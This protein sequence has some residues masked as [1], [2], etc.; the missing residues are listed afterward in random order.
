MRKGKKVNA[1]D[2]PATMVSKPASLKLVSYSKENGNELVLKARR[3]AL[4]HRDI[5]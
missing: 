4:D 2:Q 5:R 1:G 3:E